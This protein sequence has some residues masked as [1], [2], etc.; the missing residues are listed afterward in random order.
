MKSNFL[1]SLNREESFIALATVA[2]VVEGMKSA[3]ENGM[4]M[5]DLYSMEELYQKMSAQFNNQESQ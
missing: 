5:P 3:V 4:Q 1:F 2:A